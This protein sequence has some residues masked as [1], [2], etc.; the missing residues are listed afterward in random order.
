M[1]FWGL[2]A[3][4][5]DHCFIGLSQGIEV[6]NVYPV[7]LGEDLSVFSRTLFLLLWALPDFEK[8]SAFQ[9]LFN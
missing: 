5:I 3:S 1:I 9:I 4:E 8:L 6:V 7:T 2:Y